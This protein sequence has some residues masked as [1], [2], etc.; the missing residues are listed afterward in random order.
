MGGE[1]FFF[2]TL[3]F[4]LYES[5]PSLSLQ[6]LESSIVRVVLDLSVYDSTPDSDTFATLRLNLRPGEP[7]VVIAM[8]P[9]TEQRMEAVVVPFYEDFDGIGK[10]E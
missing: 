3:S 7:P 6:T 2:P 4:P 10:G 5:H 1:C 9:G 8:S